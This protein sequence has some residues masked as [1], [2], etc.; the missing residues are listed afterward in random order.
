MSHLLP[1]LAVAQHFVFDGCIFHN[2]CSQRGWYLPISMYLASR[3]I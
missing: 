3:F 1:S 2:D